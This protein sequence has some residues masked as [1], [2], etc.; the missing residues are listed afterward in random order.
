MRPE[1]RTVRTGAFVAS[2]L[3]HAGLVAAFGL[4]WAR[5]PGKPPLS[6]VEAAVEFPILLDEDAAPLT[7]PCMPENPSVPSED[8]TRRV[9]ERSADR[10]HVTELHRRARTNGRE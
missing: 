7:V 4:A 9:A 2:F 10:G 8:V 5:D 3:L 1:R 6:R